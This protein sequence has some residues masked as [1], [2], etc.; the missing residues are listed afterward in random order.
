MVVSIVSDILETNFAEESESNDSNIVAESPPVPVIREIELEDSDD[1]VWGVTHKTSLDLDIFGEDEASPFQVPVD[2]FVQNDDVYISSPAS[3]LSIEDETSIV[4]VD[5]SIKSVLIPENISID[6]YLTKLVYTLSFLNDSPI[7]NKSITTTIMQKL[8]EYYNVNNRNIIPSIDFGTTDPP[9]IILNAIREKKSTKSI[10]SD[11]K[12][13]FDNERVLTVGNSYFSFTGSVESKIVDFINKIREYYHSELSDYDN[14]QSAIGDSFLMEFREYISSLASIISD[15][16]DLVYPSCIDLS[17]MSFKCGYCGGISKYIYP[18]M[19]GSITNTDSKEWSFFILPTFEMCSSCNHSN[20]LPENIFNHIS[21]NIKA[22]FE[23]VDMQELKEKLFSL[24]SKFKMQHY[25]ISSETISEYI[26]P[27]MQ[28][29]FTFLSSD[30]VITVEEEKVASF[31]LDSAINQY[32]STISKLSGNFDTSNVVSAISG[33]SDLSDELLD[34]FSSDFAKIFC[35]ILGFDYGILKENA[36]NS[37][38]YFMEDSIPFI[39]NPVNILEAKSIYYAGVSEESHYLRLQKNFDTCLD[40]LYK[41]RDLFSFVPLLHSNISN[42]NLQDYQKDERMCKFISYCSDNMIIYSLRKEIRFI[43]EAKKDIGDILNKSPMSA[44]SLRKSLE[45]LQK[46]I[47]SDSN[48]MHI[49]VLFYFNKFISTKFQPYF[50]LDYTKLC[51]NLSSKNIYNTIKELDTISEDVDLPTF[52]PG[53]GDLRSS[54]S[55]YTDKVHKLSF[56]EFYYQDLFPDEDLSQLDC[57]FIDI[58]V[59]IEKGDLSVSDYFANMKHSEINKLEKNHILYDEWFDNHISVFFDLFSKFLLKDVS[60]KDALV[61]DIFR[62]LACNK[63]QNVLNFFKISDSIS[64]VL[65]ASLSD[66][67]FDYISP[68][69]DFAKMILSNIPYKD[70][71][72]SVIVSSSDDLDTMIDLLLS[73]YDSL[74][75]ELSDSSDLIKDNVRCLIPI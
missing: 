40:N 47:D 33:D 69:I 68:E 46:N 75:A 1:N 20:M 32:R 2:D 14:P 30:E 49:N 21:S 55:A 5:S 74:F 51:N 27:N 34:K 11:L 10:L 25:V 67:S 53:L 31:N 41:Y 36:I 22:D 64:K 16:Q 50:M 37:L 60:Y 61:M 71:D 52:L 23:K 17:S 24:S 7:S 43:G 54:L 65:I 44:T 62:S 56:A 66:F 12:Q 57:S 70:D 38:L 19:R 6:N 63:F 29:L 45:S 59:R 3:N 15:P 4:S 13:H 48:G 73:D 8:N 35:S 28:T 18:F 72:L 42:K 9:T 39:L 26:T 58:P